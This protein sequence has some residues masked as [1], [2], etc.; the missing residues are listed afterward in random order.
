MRWIRRENG[1]PAGPVDRWLR[2]DNIL[3][4]SLRQGGIYLSRDEGMNWMRVDENAETVRTT[5]LVQTGPETVIVGSQ[6]EGVL[7]LELGP[8]K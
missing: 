5:G 1:L 7:E 6:G 4:A 8:G 2:G 3:I